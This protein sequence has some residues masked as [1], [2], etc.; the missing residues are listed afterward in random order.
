MKIVND[1]G[2]LLRKFEFKAYWPNNPIYISNLNTT[3]RE[4]KQV[5]IDIIAK[6]HTYG[7]LIE[8]T[9]Q[10]TK[11]EKKIEKFIQKYRAIKESKLC[12]SKLARLFSG[13]PEEEIQRFDDVNEW[14]ALY[15]G[16]SPELIYENLIPTRFSD[17]TGLFIINIDDWNYIKIIEQAVGEYTRFEFWSHLGLNP[18][19]V[20]KIAD[21]DRFFEFHKIEKRNITKGSLEADIYQFKAP[22]EFL[23]RTCKVFRFYGLSSKETKTH[24][25]RMLSKKKLEQIRNFIKRSKKICFPTPITVVLPPQAKPRERNG[26]KLAIPF[27]YGSIDIID[28]Q[29]RVFAYASS[30][31][32]EEFLNEAALLVNGIKF[33]TDDKN[34]IRKYSARTFIDINREQLHVKTSLLYSI[35]YDIM[36]DERSI[37]LAG[38]V[39]L[40]CNSNI[41][42]PLHDLFE[43]RALRRKSKLGVHRISIVEV[44]KALS[45]IIEEIRE[46]DNKAAKNITTMI[47]LISHSHSAAKLIEIS[48]ELL[49]R[50]FNR[51]KKVL[52]KDWRKGTESTIF[53]SKY[54]A[55]FILLLRDSINE[56]Y[57]FTKIE[58][59]LWTIIANIRSMSE[60]KKSASEI[61]ISQQDQIFHKKRKGIP[62]VRFSTK[63]IFEGLKWYE[64]NDKIW[65][66]LSKG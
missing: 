46:K 33:D 49:N 45:K 40:T 52:S 6:I 22:P 62:T 15:L 30:Q 48:T 64:K 10:N 38:K 59:R 12:G 19:E 8:I 63:S 2:N 42:S 32:P 36:G 60:W 65:P 51:V 5:E 47:P 3:I 1:F 24:Y 7:F 50:Y 28:G 31:I 14:R 26:K 58:D 39:I 9:T 34:E 37:S 13:I 21:S 18:D 61:D 41:H 20:E 29:H 43:A 11:N 25:Q 23:L 66:K 55:A 53:R 57:T 54:M 56:G 17:S 35:S 16:T 4:P 27:K 44:T